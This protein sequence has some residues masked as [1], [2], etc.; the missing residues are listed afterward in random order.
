M[1]SDNLEYSTQVNGL[2]L[3]SFF[4]AFVIFIAAAVKQN[5][6]SVWQLN[7]DWISIRYN[8]LKFRLV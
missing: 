6:Y 4:G 7:D 5:D 3:W 8:I 2:R 1:V